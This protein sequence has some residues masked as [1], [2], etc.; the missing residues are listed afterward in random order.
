MDIGKI[1]TVVS[2]MTLHEKTEFVGGGITTAA[3]KKAGI[4][5]LTLSGDLLPYSAVEPSELAIGCTFSKETA[6]ALGK[7]R[8]ISAARTGAAFAGTVGCGLILNPMRTNACGFFSEDAL[9][10]AEMLES[11]SSAD[12]LGYVFTD[13]LGQGRYGDRVIDGRALHELYLYPL[14]KAGENAAALMLDGGYLN[15]QKISSSREIADMYAKYIGRKMLMTAFDDGDAFGATN[16]GAYVLSGGDFGVKELV[17]A[18]ERGDISESKIDKT[19]ERT[20]LALSAAKDFYEAY[21]DE[22]V[23]HVDIVYDSTVLLKNDGI[24]PVVNK[25]I[26]LFG[27]AEFFDDGEKFS[28]KPISAAQ[29]NIGEVN[30]FLVTDYGGG[31]SA[32]EAEIISGVA[33]NSPTVLILCGGAAT[34]I[35]MEN[36]LSAVMYCPYSP[37]IADIYKMLTGVS[38][39]GRLPFTWCKSESD[40][41]RNN[42]KFVSRGDYRYESVYNGYALFNNRKY[43]ILYPFGHGLS[44]T[45]YEITKLSVSGGDRI[46]ADFTVK[47]TGEKDG[48]A[49]VQAYVTLEGGSVYGLAKR[50]AAFKRVPLKKGESAIVGLEADMEKLRVFDDSNGDFRT[51]AGKYNVEIGLSSTDIRGAGKVKLVSKNT[52]APRVTKEQAPSYYILGGAFEPTAPEIEKILSVPFIAKRE[53]HPELELPSSE[54]IKPIIKR[55]KKTVSPRLFPRVKYKIENTPIKTER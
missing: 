43:D 23:E 42:K 4:P 52:I 40:Y 13:S 47:N 36:S 7:E 14:G 21:K 29:K 12:G 34:P 50:L 51:V 54:K 45:E 35:P 44:Y 39:R 32:E 1:R 26:S 48:V 6:A 31:L 15:G 18:V 8:S 24:L 49:V 38:P 16:S 10:A 28:V 27:A 46:T 17:R 2:E 33:Q 41:P 5:K 22:Q 55:A 53:N 37:R 19:V 11:Y 25:K 20:L 30:A 3:L 9:L